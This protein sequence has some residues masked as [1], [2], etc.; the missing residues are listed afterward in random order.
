MVA[1]SGEDLTISNPA[2]SG[3]APLCQSGN[4]SQEWS[5]TKL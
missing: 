4:E 5:S 2:G 3:V 1:I